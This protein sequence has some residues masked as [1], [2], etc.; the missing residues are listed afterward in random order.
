[1]C[2]LSKTEAAPEGSGSPVSLCP[3]LS[4]AGKEGTKGFAPFCLPRDLV[5]EHG[6]CTLP[7]PGPRPSATENGLAVY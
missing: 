1:M 6:R 4:V 2:P 3:V 5:S 7:V